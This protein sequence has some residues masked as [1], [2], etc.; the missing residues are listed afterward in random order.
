LFLIGSAWFNRIFCGGAPMSHLAGLG[1]L[2]IAAFALQGAAPLV[3]GCVA[4]AILIGVSIWESVEAA[5]NRA[6]L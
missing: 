6:D 1:A 4:T 5:H 2:A 3:L